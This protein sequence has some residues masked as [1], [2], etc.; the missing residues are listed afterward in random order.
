MEPLEGMESGEIL[1]TGFDL[2]QAKISVSLKPTKNNSEGSFVKSSDIFSLLSKHGITLDVVSLE[3]SQGGTLMFTMQDVH[4][5]RASQLLTDMH[6]NPVLKTDLATI[7]I[8]GIG[9]NK[10]YIICSIL[11]ICESCKV[12][13]DFITLSETRIEILT[14][15]LESIGKLMLL[16]QAKSS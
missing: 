5:P 14:P 11:E 1:E 2:R 12:E 8:T 6:L 13:V 16:L 10:P 4:A 15:S 3:C 7:Y 9:I